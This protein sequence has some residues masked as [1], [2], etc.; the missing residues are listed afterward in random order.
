MCNTQ[1]TSSSIINIEL[2]QLLLLY[3]VLLTLYDV[4]MIGLKFMDSHTKPLRL[5]DQR[6][7]AILQWSD[8]LVGRL[9]LRYVS[10]HQTL[11]INI[12]SL[13]HKH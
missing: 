9:F 10:L 3:Q 8:A 7:I 4:L 6:V 1:H 2:K 13:N 11:H 5:F 12:L